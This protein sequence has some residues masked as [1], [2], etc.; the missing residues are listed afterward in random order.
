MRNPDSFLR[1]CIKSLTE[2]YLYFLNSRFSQNY[3]GDRA[4]VAISLQKISTIDRWLSSAKTANE[5]FDMMDLVADCVKREQINR[6]ENKDS[7]RTY[8]NKQVI[9]V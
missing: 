3:C 4:E 9:E 2:D 6:T 5:W 1:N 7:N 8:R